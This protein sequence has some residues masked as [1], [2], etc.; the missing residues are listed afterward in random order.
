MGDEVKNTP[1]RVQPDETTINIPPELPIPED[2]EIEYEEAD[3][4]SEIVGMCV[5]AIEA[6]ESIDLSLMPKNM[7]SRKKRTI[8]RSLII[9]DDII[10]QLY[11]ELNEQESEPED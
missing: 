7:E 4:R 10:G 6:F 8:R 9:I 11:T 3:R 5:G 1:N 2:E